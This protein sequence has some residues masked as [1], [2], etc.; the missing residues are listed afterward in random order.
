[1]VNNNHINADRILHLQ[2]YECFLDKKYN[3]SFS[4]LCMTYDWRCYENDHIFM[5][6]PKSTWGKFDGEIA[7]IARDII[8]TEV[9]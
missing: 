3:V 8:E 6:K 5:L 7:E 4:D 9:S 2:L 1:M